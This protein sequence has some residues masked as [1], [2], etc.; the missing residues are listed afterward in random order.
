MGT[1]TPVKGFYKPDVNEK[2]WAAP[3]N[4]N[5]DTV[6]DELLAH[7][8]DIAT[9]VADAATATA[10]AAAAL[11][12]KGLPMNLAGA[13]QAT[14]YVG[15]RTSSA[16]TGNTWELGDFMILQNGGV[17]IC[18]AAG[19]PGTWVTI[20]AA[21]ASGRVGADY[22]IYKSGSNY[23][24]RNNATGADEF[25]ST[26]AASVVQSAHDALGK[27]GVVQLVR[28]VTYT[29]TSQV[30]LS[31]AGVLVC[32]S[33][34]VGED[35]PTLWQVTSQ[36]SAGNAAFRITGSGAGL[37]GISVDAN[38][39]ADYCVDLRSGGGYFFESNVKNADVAN[40]YC[41]GPNGAARCTFWNI[42]SDNPSASGG[43]N[44]KLDGPDHIA[45]GLRATGTAASGYSFWA[46]TSRLMVVGGHLTGVE[47][48]AGDVF[49][50]GSENRLEGFYL[51]TG[52][53]GTNAATLGGAH[54]TIK[55]SG[56]YISALIQNAG[57]QAAQTVDQVVL[58]SGTTYRFRTTSAHD[59]VV[60]QAV[61]L[62]GFASSNGAFQSTSSL[63]ALITAVSDNTHFDVDLGAA[64]TFTDQAG[65]SKKIC[66][67]GLLLQKTSSGSFVQ[68]NEFHIN[69]QGKG[70][71]D[72]NGEFYYAVGFLDESSNNPANLARFAANRFYINA[73]NCTR[74][75]NLE[76]TWS[77]LSDNDKIFIDAWHYQQDTSTPMKWRTKAR[78]LT[79]AATGSSFNV[80]HGLA[81]TPSQIQITPRADPG[82]GVS[83]WISAVGQ[84]SFTISSSASITNARWYWQAEL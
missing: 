74:F 17:A 81:G 26:N 28:G 57:T 20:T 50:S 46:D 65:T 7:E 41:D 38:S 3:V 11:A 72:N 79:A 30:I 73:A 54:V 82:A 4:N 62:E 32:S 34:Q 25:S 13:T 5:F 36:L 61:W 37:G 80:S 55:G 29:A 27:A 58:Q 22:T 77:T 44:F 42:R 14:R 48:S 71:G 83:W 64:T 53:S 9:A 19:T 23:I 43:I 67:Y 59:Y 45:W 18:T 8:A 69:F 31:Q 70:A 47:T 2:N 52:P 56:N 63:N 33:P 60:G 24:A 15:G 35:Q 68:G 1:T 6:E 21:G 49:I 12:A 40:F 16:P 75:S 51:D 10:N 78:G 76:S 39:L 66:K 84:S